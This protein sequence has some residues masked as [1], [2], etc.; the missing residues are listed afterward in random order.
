MKSKI[1]RR[2]V[3]SLLVLASLSLPLAGC[4]RGAKDPGGKDPDDQ[5]GGGTNKP[6]D[7]KDLP[8]YIEDYGNMQYTTED[9]EN[10]MTKP[11]WLGN[12]IYNELALP[13][14]YDNG[15]MYANLLYTPLKVI[16]VMD[17]KLS[18][19]YE[20]GKD[21]T[22]DKANK[23]LII[24]ENSTVPLLSEHAEH[25]VNIPEGYEYASAPDAVSKYTVWGGEPGSATAYVYTESSLFYGRYLSVTYAYDVQELP[26]GVFNEFDALSLMNFRSKLEAGENVSVAFVGDSITD[27]SSSTGDNLKVDPYTPCYAKQLCAEI[28][29]VY[30]VEVTYTNGAKGGTTSDWPLSGEGLLSFNRVL[31]AKPDLCVI[32]YGMNDSTA[33]PPVSALKYQMNI[34]DILLR[35]RAVAPDCNFILV[36]S[37]PCNPLYEKQAGLFDN[38]AAKLK[39]LEEKYDPSSVKCIDMQTVGKNFLQIKRY[40]E[41]SSSNVNHPNDFLHRVY[42]MNLMT[43]VTDYK[44]AK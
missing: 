16:S 12:V 27:G 40:C 24:P 36:N 39:E 34:E 32:A 42:A 35:V 15:E 6:V 26:G 37:F 19:T 17:Q 44:K 41:I 9:Y 1:W 29:R 14:E 13:I 2:A 30:G 43:A 38:Y 31:E 3:A 25:G 28:E 11:Y 20:E 5:G 8:F 4:D 22:V 23:R 18:K 21:Y 33:S 10:S 7:P